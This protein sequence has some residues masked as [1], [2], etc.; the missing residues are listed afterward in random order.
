MS[1][2]QQ[3][4]ID[5]DFSAELEEALGLNAQAR[6][7][8][9]EL[10]ELA[11]KADLNP[12]QASISLIKSLDEALLSQAYQNKYAEYDDRLLCAQSLAYWVKFRQALL[13]EAMHLLKDGDPAAHSQTNASPQTAARPATISTP[14]TRTQPFQP[15]GLKPAVTS[16]NGFRPGQ[17]GTATSQPPAQRSFQPPASQTKGPGFNPTRQPTVQQSTTMHTR[18]AS[19]AP[20]PAPTP[21]VF[22]FGAPK[23]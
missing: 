5:F 7:S 13:K 3:E 2:I 12:E 15:V 23:G 17:R 21:P 8:L 4:L 20:N 22:N 9:F 6:N 11:M 18:S 16:T 1:S 19:P 10:F 14:S